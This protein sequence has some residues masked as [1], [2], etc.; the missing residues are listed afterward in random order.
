MSR[1][2]DAWIRKSGPLAIVSSIGLGL[3]LW[4]VCR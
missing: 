1:T 2:G 3:L 4:S